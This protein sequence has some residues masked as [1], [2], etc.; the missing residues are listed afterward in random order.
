MGKSKEFF[1]ASVEAYPEYF[2]TRVL[3]AEEWAVK[4][5]DRASFEQ[6]LKANVEG[7]V[8]AVPEIAAENT[9]EQRKSERLLAD[10]DEYF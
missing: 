5:G 9:C 6:L 4:E 3:M 10:I 8:N 2:G 7:D 1:E